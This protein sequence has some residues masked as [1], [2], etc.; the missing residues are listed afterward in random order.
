MIEIYSDECI[1]GR[2]I[3]VSIDEKKLLQAESVS[4]RKKA[5]IHRVR[6]CFHSEDIAHIRNGTV[7]RV[8]LEGIRFMRPFQNCNF[9]DLDNFTM[10]ME[11]DGRKII[12]SGCLWDDFSAAADK[13]AFREHI[14]AVALNIKTEDHNE[15][16]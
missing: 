10:S 12:L 7:Y 15:G 11:A 1:C 13:S 6:S 8:T 3:I 16:K 2:D 9:A 14:S 4:I 5:D